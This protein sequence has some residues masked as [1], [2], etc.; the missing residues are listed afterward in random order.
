MSLILSRLA[1]S[2]SA[3]GRLIPPPLSAIL[4]KDDVV[5]RQ[6][7]LMSSSCRHKIAMNS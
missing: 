5:V 2:I 7:A 6:S 4:G 1:D 3:P